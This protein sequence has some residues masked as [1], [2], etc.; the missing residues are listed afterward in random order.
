VTSKQRML[1]ALKLGV[2]DRLPVTTHHV[3][4]YF[5]NHCLRGIGVQE[6]FDQFGLDPILWLFSEQNRPN[7]ARGEYYDPVLKDHIVSDSWRVECEEMTDQP[8]AKRKYT[9]TTPKG[10]L[11]AATEENEQTAWLTE[12]LIKSKEDVDVIGEYMT[13][14]VCDVDAVNR[15]AEAFG[16]RGLLRGMFP[17]FDLFGQPGCWQDAACLMGI[18]NLIMATFDDSSWVHTLLKTLLCRKL[19][20][21]RTAEGAHY[22][23][24]ELGGGDA[25][26][27][28]ISPQIFDKFVAPY[29]SELIRAAHEAGLRVVYH[30]CGGMMP[31]LENIASLRPDAMETFT[32]PGMGGD[33]DLGEAKDRIGDKACMIGGF[34]QLHFF[35]DCTPEIT[36]AEVR[37]CF[38][39][40]GD[41]GGFI[42]CPSDHFFDAEPGLIA[43]FADE[44]RQCTY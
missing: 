36:R 14:P 9:V 31:I 25:S 37:R 35:K 41:G 20:W 40:A 44:A 4:P 26:S 18:E 12:H 1:T 24:L 28:V 38:E 23:I 27:T 19:N 17:C 32:P 10:A 2:P 42:L 11:T 29:D 7:Q 5:L 39:Q 21:I 22:D 43:A 34:D 6:F 15:E 8:Y 30:T 16:E 33:S 3:M 13:M